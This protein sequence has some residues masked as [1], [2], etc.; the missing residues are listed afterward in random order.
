MSASQ[1]QERRAEYSVRSAVSSLQDLLTSQSETTVRNLQRL[2][3]KNLTAIDRYK[4][5]NTAAEG[6]AADGDFLRTNNEEIA[7]YI[8]QVDDVS[9]G[10]ERLERLVQEMNEWSKELAVKVKR[11]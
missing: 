4:E 8:G 9:N 3:S 11:L 6:L 5:M 10:I 1:A 7:R 2:E